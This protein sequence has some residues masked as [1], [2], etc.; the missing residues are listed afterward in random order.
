MDGGFLHSPDFLSVG[1]SSR[2]R[3]EPDV[4][5]SSHMKSIPILVKMWHIGAI[6]LVSLITVRT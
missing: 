3:E 5:P 4:S 6:M 2:N 1:V